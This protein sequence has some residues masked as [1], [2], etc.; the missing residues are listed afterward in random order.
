MASDTLL[1]FFGN[2]AGMGGA[3]LPVGGGAAKQ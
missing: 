2:A 1:L 3:L